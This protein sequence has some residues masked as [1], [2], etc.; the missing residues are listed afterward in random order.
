M[1][2]AKPL[3]EL[4]KKDVPFIW[5]DQHTEALDR[6]IHKVTTAPYW[7]AQT[8]ISNFPWK[9]THPPLP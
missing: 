8:Q 3:T 2:L 7:H 5:E 4:T 9:S 6:L 1:A